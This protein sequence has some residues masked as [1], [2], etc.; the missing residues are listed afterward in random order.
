MDLDD[1]I[2]KYA[3]KNAYQHNGKAEAGAVIGKI[4][5]EYPELRKDTKDA[6]FYPFFND[7]C[8]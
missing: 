2:R 7:R 8:L 4:L 3:L 6:A 1:E 5:A